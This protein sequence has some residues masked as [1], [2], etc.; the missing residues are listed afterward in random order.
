MH[1]DRN[2]RYATAR[3][4]SQAVEAYA[5]ETGLTLNPAA[6]GEF[7]E[8]TMGPKLEPWKV[9]GGERAIG[10]QTPPSPFAATLVPATFSQVDSG[11]A[12]SSDADTVAELATPMTAT[13]P[14][15]A[16]WVIVGAA[17]LG[18]FALVGATLY[19]RAHRRPEPA[20]GS[21]V[22]VAERGSAQIETDA[23]AGAATASEPD[24]A[25]AADPEPEPDAGVKIKRPPPPPPL[26]SLSAAFSRRQNLVTRCVETHGGG[27]PVQLPGLA[28]R[29]EID[30]AGVPTKV[31]VFPADV[32][33][34]PL[35]ACIA[36]VGRG[37]RF[38]RQAA[39]TAFKIPL[40]VRASGGGT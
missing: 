36:D 40:T 13:R 5:R 17:T 30:A 1:V 39:P 37:T 6:L 27:G 35:G 34:T 33:R 29:F 7:L 31:D 8:H 22:L 10:L 2:E 20:A 4:L 38:P 24:A 11:T 32:A 23:G 21:V 19:W 25:T 15:R 28:L 16:P 3:E 12:A 14:S 9:A 18:A 26:D